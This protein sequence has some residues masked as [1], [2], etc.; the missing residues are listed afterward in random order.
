MQ[1]ATE[2]FEILMKFYLLTAGAIEVTRVSNFPYWAYLHSV[3][4]WSPK[5]Y[6]AAVDD[7]PP[8]L[9]RVTRG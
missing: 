4:G 7:P 6:F 8:L 5:I 3:N 1:P 2:A 9:S